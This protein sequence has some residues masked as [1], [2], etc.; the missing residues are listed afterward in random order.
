VD[1][2]DIPLFISDDCFLHLNSSDRYYFDQNNS[3]DRMQP[4][5]QSNYV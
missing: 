5:P 3:A 1:Y 2:N 4:R